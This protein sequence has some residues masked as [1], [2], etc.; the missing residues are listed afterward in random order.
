[1]QAISHS[2]IPHYI[3][4]S[5][6]RRVFVVY[7]GGSAAAYEAARAD[8]YRK[9]EDDKGGHSGGKGKGG[10]GGGNSGMGNMGMNVRSNIS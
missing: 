3:T 5:L 4:T 1:M 10:G 8:H 7:I 6:R 2:S 9:M